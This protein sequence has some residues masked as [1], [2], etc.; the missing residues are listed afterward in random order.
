M[1]HGIQLI[2]LKGIKIITKPNGRKYQ[3]L[4]VGHAFVPLPN[5]P[6]NDPDF[7][8]AYVDAGNIP[9]PQ[10]ST[11]NIKKDSIASLIVAYRSSNTWKSLSGNTRKSRIRILDK[12]RKKGGEAMVADLQSHHIRRDINGLE[13]HPAK[14][15]LKVWRAI[16]NFAVEEEWIADSP[17]R[18]VTAK[19]PE[20]TGHRPWTEAE[21]EQFRNHCDIGTNER[22]AFEIFYWTGARCSDARRL[23]HQML[24][25]KGWITFAQQKTGGRVVIPFVGDLP[26]WLH[27]HQIDYSHL[28]AS[29]AHTP[30]DAS[31][32]IQ[33]IYGKPR[34]EK[35]ISNWMNEIATKAGLPD[36]CTGHGIRKSRAIRLAENGASIH[37]IGAWTGHASLKEI[38]NNT[39]EANRRKILE[40]V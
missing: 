5:L 17:A 39:R 21:I 34:S 23:G 3:Y 25:K 27:P 24:D 28:Q 30:N 14:N 26:D 9:A 33:T 12:I 38:E 4:R 22:I 32:L 10:K 11:Q 16:L 1:R 35:G 19:L 31:T 6:H 13:P 37:Q 20:T 18:M 36:D 8:R 7:I 40:G 2:R 15:R 29:L